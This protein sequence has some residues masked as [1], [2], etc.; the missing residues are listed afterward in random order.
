MGG[1]AQLCGKLAMAVG[2]LAVSLAVGQASAQGVG[3][4][5]TVRSPSVSAPGVGA[6]GVSPSLS[7]SIAPS[8][9]P[10]LTP[11]VTPGVS[12]SLS[13]A[14]AAPPAAAAAPVAAAPV[15]SP[16]VRFRCE[17]APYDQSCREPGAPDGGGDDAECRC[18]RD[19]CYD[20][21]DAAAGY[22]TRICEKQ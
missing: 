14:V 12:P 6:V 7:P 2:A 9:S 10:S 11:S 21:Y 16:V 1:K 22:T 13:G 19:P 5:G 18:G 4:T 17:V 20:R 3:V 8:L 15:A